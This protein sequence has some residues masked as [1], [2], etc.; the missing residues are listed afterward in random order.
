M[1]KSKVVTYPATDN[2][3]VQI[4]DFKKQESRIVFGPELIL[5]GPYEQITV[6]GVS[7][8]VPKRENALQLLCLPLGQNN[9]EDEITVETNDHAS[10]SLRLS[11]SAH[12]RVTQ[13]I[14]EET[15]GKL[16]SIIDYIGIAC[17]T[18]ASR[19]RGSVSSISYDQF[20]HNY[21][22][23]IKKAVFGSSEDFVFEENNFVITECD[24]KSQE[25]IDENI[26]EMLKK[27]T[28]L[29]IQLKT[30]ANELK[31]DLQRKLLEEESNGQLVLQKL[32][33]EKKAAS[34][35]INLQQLKVKSDEVE[36]F[37]KMVK[38]IGSHT[39]A[40]MARAGPESRAQLLKSL[41]IEG[42]LVTDGKTPVNIFKAA[43]GFIRK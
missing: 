7:G 12:F 36:K 17:K 9:F 18:I 39:I 15:P 33:D 40:E 23:I 16:F 4:H 21:S 43:E 42:Y 31:Y 22:N 29:A 8:D 35:Q 32:E 25:L 24:V 28:S 37:Q 3:A 41:G 5:L 27:N 14:R 11:Y 38:A 10:M 6:L 13:E 26:R 30:K 1:G 34:A 20:H 19:I 2:T